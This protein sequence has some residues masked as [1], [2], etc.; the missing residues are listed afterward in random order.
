[1]AAPEKRLPGADSFS[2]A[3]GGPFNK[4]IERLGSFRRWHKSVQGICWTAITWLPLLVLSAERATAWGNKVGIPLLSDPSVFARF[5]VALPLLV[6]ADVVIGRFTRDAVSTLNCSGIIGEED[7]PWFRGVLERIARLRD[8]SIA[9]LVLLVLACIPFYLLFAD[10]E[11]S[12]NGVSTWHGTTS[13]G[14]SPAGWWFTYISS[15]ILRFFMLRWL[16]RYILWSYL[17]VK[18]HQLHLILVPSHPDRIGGLGF[19]LRSQQHFAI[20]ATALSSVIAG[21]FANEILYFDQ[22]FNGIRAPA[23][24]FVA[25]AVLTILGPLTC[26]SFKLF[27]A[28]YEALRRNSRTGRQ[29]AATFDLKWT[30]GVGAPPETMIGS[31]DPSSMIDYVSTCDV[32]RE[33]RVI[34]INKGAITYVTV[35]AALPFASLWLLNKSLERLVAEVLKRLLE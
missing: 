24:V 27:T 25:I 21:Q 26:F 32:I 3:T 30:R 15:P 33:T 5:F 7:L 19:L 8:S 16:W 12:N 2:I 17:L 6:S 18:A 22:T 29:V 4:A 20:V 13:Q 23:T 11:W 28:R 31:Q 1:M 14:L 10:Y 34:P 35:L 9:E